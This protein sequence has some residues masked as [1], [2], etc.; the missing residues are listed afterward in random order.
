MA[1][2][3]FGSVCDQIFAPLGIGTLTLAGGTLVKGFIC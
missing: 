2:A 1:A 3:A